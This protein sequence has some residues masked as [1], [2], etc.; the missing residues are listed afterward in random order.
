[1][2]QEDPKNKHIEPEHQDAA[3]KP[4]PET[5][6]AEP[7]E[8]MKGPVSSVMKKIEET[9]MDNDGEVPEEDYSDEDEQKRKAE[10]EA[11]KNNH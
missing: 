4:D 7:Q 8:H 10:A 9:F 1:M 3:V 6:G 11:K 2:K 5:L